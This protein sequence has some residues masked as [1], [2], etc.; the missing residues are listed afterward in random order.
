MTPIRPVRVSLEVPMSAPALVQRAARLGL[1]VAAA[2]AFLAPLL[3]RITVGYALFLTG[4][5][6]LANLEGFVGFLSELGV[7]LAHAQ[8]PFIAGLELVGGICLVLGLLTRLM[9][10]GLLSTMLVAILAAD[11]ENFVNAWLP[12][13][14][15]GPL[16]IAPYV[17]FLL[18]SWLVLYGPGPVSLDRLLAKPLGLA[19]TEGASQ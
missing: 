14:D 8:A 17:F 2:L 9:S 10:A 18:L 5:G 11:R 1:R 12:T 4:R 3:T 6:K 19:E 16:D 13:G 15:V 7:P